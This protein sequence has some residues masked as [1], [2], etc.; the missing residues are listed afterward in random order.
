ME[1]RIGW[2][3]SA[4]A[5]AAA[6]AAI[7][8]PAARADSFSEW[9]PVISSTPIVQRMSQPQEQCWTE[10]VT[11]TETRRLSGITIGA[12]DTSTN[13]VV[14]VTRDIQRCRTVESYTD[15]V[16]SYD[17]RYRY[18]GREYTTRMATDP[19][20]RIRVDVNVAPGVR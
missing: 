20:D 12:L 11:T 13:V 7:G 14:P 18:N 10:Q 3:R 1:Y 17:V 2:T 16:Q 9:A 15:V 6:A 8:A 4:L 5:L 19:G